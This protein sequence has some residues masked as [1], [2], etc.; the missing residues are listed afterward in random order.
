MFMA[1][2]K[3][4]FVWQ[5]NAFIRSVLMIRTAIITMPVMGQNNVKIIFVNQAHPSTAMTIIHAQQ[6]AVI[7][8]QAYAKMTIPVQDKCA[9][10]EFVLSV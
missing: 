1:A 6:I 2:V 4:K 8:F 3:M 9:K 10:E 5:I 7:L